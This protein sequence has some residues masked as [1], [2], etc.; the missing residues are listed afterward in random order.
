M[1]KSHRLILFNELFSIF[2]SAQQ[3]AKSMKTTKLESNEN[4]PKQKY[5]VMPFRGI[6]PIAM[7]VPFQLLTHGLINGYVF[8]ASSSPDLCF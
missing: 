8:N 4:S 2:F 3:V 5:C 1:D 7:S 6:P